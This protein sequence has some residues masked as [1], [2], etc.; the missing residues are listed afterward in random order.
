[1]KQSVWLIGSGP[2][3]VEYVKVLKAQQLET[4]VIGRGRESAERFRAETGCD[5]VAGG[6]DGFLSAQPVI[7]DAVIVS[8]GVAQL[9]PTALRLLEYGVKRILLEKPGGLNAEQVG[10]VAEQALL[11]NAEVVVAYNRRFYGSVQRAREII[12]EDGGVTSFNFEF[13][14]WS[15]VIA[16]LKTAPEVKDRWFLANSSHVV[17]L[18]FHLGGIPQEISVCHAGGLSWH[19][20]ASVFSGSGVSAEG[21]LFSYQANWEAP[22]RWGV[23]VLTRKHRLYLRPMEEL[24]IQ[25]VGSIKIEKAAINNPFDTAFKPGLFLQVKSFLAKD[26]ELF[27]GIEEHLRCMP[28]YESMAKY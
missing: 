8:V 4:T 19:P 5:V 1:M 17:D 28:I 27:C 13:T 20:A 16:A 12:E 11:R 7:P 22:G 18:A 21:A 2:M 14:E 9:A 25:K 6:L 10:A 26:S 15:H 24:G 3:A 23:E